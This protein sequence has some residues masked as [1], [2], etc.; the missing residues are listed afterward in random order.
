MFINE[1]SEDMVH[2]S[3]ECSWGV[4]E[5]KEHHRWFEHTVWGFEHSFPFVAL[6][7]T[8]VV[9]SPSDVEFREDEHMDQIGDSLFNI[10]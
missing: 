8:D 5:S 4:S 10:W 7:D 1:W 3:L 2:H 6:L 9:I